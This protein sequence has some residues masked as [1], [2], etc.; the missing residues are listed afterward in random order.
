MALETNDKNFKY[1]VLDSSVPVLVDFWAKWCGPCRILGPIIDQ[2]GIKSLG[3]AKVY[4]LNIDE[5]PVTT[6]KYKITAVP[7]VIIFK[8]GMIHNTLLG[9]QIEKNYLDALGL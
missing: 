4:K 1:D 5:N 6:E 2:I 3:K 9:V 8:N 7:T